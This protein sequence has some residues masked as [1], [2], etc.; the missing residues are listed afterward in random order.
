[1]PSS[2]DPHRDYTRG[3]FED[4]FLYHFVWEL[5]GGCVW[6]LIGLGL[7]LAGWLSWQTVRL[8]CTVIF[9]GLSAWHF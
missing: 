4:S 5:L 9:E 2:F 3:T 7:R 8:L 6:E 1:M